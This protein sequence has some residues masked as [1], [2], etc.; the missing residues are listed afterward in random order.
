[1]LKQIAEK[2]ENLEEMI[3]AQNGKIDEILSKLEE[4]DSG[5]G[6]NKQK[7]K[8]KGKS[9]NEFYQVNIRHLI[10]VFVYYA[11]F[12][13][14]INLIYIHRSQSENWLMKYFINTSR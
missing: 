9:S 7:G 13:L 10:N 3:N 12:I 8:D 2:Q 14:T 6:A 5:V 4:R 1:M 11:V